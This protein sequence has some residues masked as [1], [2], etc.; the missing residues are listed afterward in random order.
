MSSIHIASCKCGYEKR[1]M[2]GGLMDGYQDDSRF[3]FYC[4]HCGLVEA[5]IAKI[6]GK[7]LANASLN[8]PKESVNAP[9]CPDCGSA[10][11]D[12][13]G[14]PPASL[15]PDNHPQALQA[16]G[17]KASKTGNLCPKCK[18]MSLV[19]SSSHICID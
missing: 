16:W 19:F 15:P 7:D 17:F 13:Y 1:I 18:Q 10:D 3:P 5:N 6:I 12:Q 14:I 4:Q 2:V 9:T 8:N 11:I